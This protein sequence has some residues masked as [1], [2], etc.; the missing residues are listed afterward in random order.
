MLWSKRLLFFACVTVAIAAGG[1]SA[2]SASAGWAPNCYFND[3]QTA[4][5]GYWA[6][7]YT[8]RE[9][10]VTWDTG[11]TCTGMPTGDISVYKIT[12][13]VKYT[14][15][16]G[17]PYNP[18]HGIYSRQLVNGYAHWYNLSTDECHGVCT[19]SETWYP[20]TLMPADANATYVY[21]YYHTTTGVW[22]SDNYYFLK[23]TITR[24]NVCDVFC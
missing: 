11:R 22:N 1:F 18:N 10:T 12:E 5:K 7:P 2:S 6:D 14:L 16:P 24:Q 8:H 19:V 15:N 9:V 4:A 3:R 21:T 13:S 20:G 23:D 17:Y